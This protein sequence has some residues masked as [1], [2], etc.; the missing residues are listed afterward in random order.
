MKTKKKGIR[1]FQ[2]LENECIWMKAGVISL[3]TCNKVYDCFD[4][5]FDKAMTKAMGEKANQETASNWAEYFKKQ[6]DGNSR[7]C[8]HVLTGR[9]RQ[10]K[11][12]THNY[13]CHD[14]AFDQML[15]DVEI[16]EA[17]TGPEYMNA[18]GFTLAQDYYYHDG[19]TWVRIE[20]GG[21]ARIGFDDFIMKLFG[22]AEFVPELMSIGSFMEKGKPGWSITQDNH[23]A[24]VISPISGTVLSVNQRA[25]DN[26]DI[27][28]DDPYQDGWLFVVEP[29]TPLKSLK[30]L[31]FGKDSI[32][33]MEKENSKLMDMMGPEYANL[34][35]TG[36]EP[37]KDFFGFNPE[38]G[39]DNLVATF[40]KT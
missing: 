14:C 22:K 40:L 32:N 21:M 11:I 25:K 13:E 33:W 18:S 29:D 12:C 23:R 9:I 20:H 1:G 6:F 28:H 19:H 38:I 37:V 17:Q 8:R 10:P 36:G 34:A 24:S 39:W 27:M 26:P 35:A 7:P 15:D 2:V 16:S 31:R 4:C 3:H 30:K 5:K